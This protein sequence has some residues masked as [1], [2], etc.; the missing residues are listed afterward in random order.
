MSLNLISSSL[1]Y[2]KKINEFPHHPQII[3]NNL[4]HVF[5]NEMYY[6][7]YEKVKLMTVIDINYF[8]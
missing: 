8:V 5:Q 4:P 1:S 7:Y 6:M 2:S 3:L